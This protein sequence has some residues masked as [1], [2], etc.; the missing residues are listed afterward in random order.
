MISCLAMKYDATICPL[1]PTVHRCL[2]SYIYFPHKIIGSAHIT[3]VWGI[4]L[5]QVLQNNG[6]YT[7]HEVRV[8][9]YP[10]YYW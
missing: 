4:S 9:V 1:T 2:L 6:Q 5:K 7:L 10:R 3:N 8:A